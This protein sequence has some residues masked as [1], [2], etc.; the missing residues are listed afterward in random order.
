MEK[1]LYEISVHGCDDCTIFDMELTKEEFELIKK[2]AGK[3]TE[4]STSQCMPRMEV[5]K[6]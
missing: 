1:Q 3:C 5:K 6:K 4:T 2:V